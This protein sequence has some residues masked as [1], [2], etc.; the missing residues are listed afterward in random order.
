MFWRFLSIGTLAV[1]A[2]CVGGATQSAEKQPIELIV[3]EGATSVRRVARG[4]GRYELTYNLQAEFPAEHVVMQIRATLS[5]ARWQP[6]DYD[7]LNPGNPSGYSRGWSDFIDGTKTP[8]TVVHVWS[9]EWK[10][11][12]GALVIYSLRYDSAV[13]PGGF[14]RPSPD[15]HVLKVRAL[16]FPSAIVTGMRKQLGITEPLQ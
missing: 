2:A 6:L 11:R 9:A 10:D 15:N 1:L 4:D 13:P 16:F 12:T 14:T 7:W 5:D 3:Y 8:N